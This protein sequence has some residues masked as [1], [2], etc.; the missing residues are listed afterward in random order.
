MKKN[1]WLFSL[2]NFFKKYEHDEE[3]ELKFVV[4]KLM[5]YVT[6]NNDLGLQSVN[7]RKIYLKSLLTSGYSKLKFSSEKQKNFNFTYQ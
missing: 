2:W 3:N 5:N 6:K 4:D 7:L 1:D